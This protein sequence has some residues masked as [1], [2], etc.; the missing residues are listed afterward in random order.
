VQTLELGDGIEPI[1][2]ALQA[3]RE[4]YVMLSSVETFVVGVIFLIN[5]VSSVINL[6]SF[7]FAKKVYEAS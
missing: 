3:V 2:T 5:R 1:N 7:A 6:R 4:V